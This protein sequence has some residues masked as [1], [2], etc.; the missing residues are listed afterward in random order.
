MDSR[1]CLHRWNR[2][3]AGCL[4]LGENLVIQ[5]GALGGL[6]EV[7][8]GL[9]E[10]SEVEGGNFFSFFNLLLVALDLALELVD[11]GLHAFVVLA[12]LVSLE[13]ELLDLPLP[14]P[15]VLLGISKTS[16]LGIHFRLEFPDT[17][18]EFAHGLLS[19]LESVLF[20]I[21]KTSLHAH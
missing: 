5:I 18:L 16:A 7:V 20:G 14:L 2:T 12:V 15:Q 6:S 9:A 8:L 10:L 13:G 17:A 21:I 11:K 19:S 3:T 4:G 1:V